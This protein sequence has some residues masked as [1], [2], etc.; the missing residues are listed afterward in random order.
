MTECPNFLVCG[1]MYDPTLKVCRSCFW[2]FKNQ[3][4]E[5]KDDECSICHQHVKCVKYRKYEDFVCP[6]CFN[7]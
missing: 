1:K 5:F 4:L 7:T 3:V 6:K 2:R